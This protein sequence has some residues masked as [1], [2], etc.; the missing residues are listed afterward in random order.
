MLNSHLFKNTWFRLPEFLN[1]Q[2]IKFHPWKVISFD[3]RLLLVNNQ[4]TEN[5]LKIT[6]E[7]FVRKFTSR[8]NLVSIMSKF[9]FFPVEGDK[10]LHFQKES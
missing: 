5:F 9:L 1:F 2:K 8:D 4:I 6:P 7:D 3:G 10:C